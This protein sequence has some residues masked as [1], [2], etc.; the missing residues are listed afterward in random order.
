ME[1]CSD[2]N[3]KFYYDLY[4]RQIKENSKC[5]AAQLIESVKNFNSLKHLLFQ[6]GGILVQTAKRLAIVDNQLPNSEFITNSVPSTDHLKERMFGKLAYKERLMHAAHRENF[7]AL[8]NI[9]L[10]SDIQTI[11]N[12]IKS[13]CETST[14]PTASTAILEYNLIG[15]NEIMNIHQLLTEY[16]DQRAKNAQLL[17]KNKLL[18][19]KWS[20]NAHNDES[21]DE[22]EINMQ[23]CRITSNAVDSF[24]RKHRDEVEQQVNDKIH[25][26]EGTIEMFKR[27]MDV[28]LV[29]IGHVKSFHNLKCANLRKQIEILTRRYD[30]EKKQ[31]DDQIVVTKA[32]IDDAHSKYEVVFAWHNDQGSFIAEYRAEQATREANRQIENRKRLAAIYIQAWWKGIMVRHQLGPYRPKKG[33]DDKSK[34]KKAKHS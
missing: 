12:V 10:R 32:K 19:E 31:L 27:K 23:W 7:K 26:I 29:T 3:I 22:L 4:C 11:H 17:E 1:T 20:K 24:N 5:N 25:E 8:D 28:E 16:Y 13:H 30:I 2:Q 15:M 18:H 33:K 14:T 6:I 9:K 34:K 21:N